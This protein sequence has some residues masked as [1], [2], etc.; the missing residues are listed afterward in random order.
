[1]EQDLKNI[2]FDFGGVLVDLDRQ[3]VFD[4][5]QKLGVRQIEQW[6]KFDLAPFVALENGT[7]TEADFYQQLRDLA[8]LRPEITDME[9]AHAWNS[10]L[11]RIPKQRLEALLR[12]RQRYRVF[13]LSN[14]NSIHWEYS[15]RHLFST[16]GLSAQDYFDRIYL[17]Y[18]LHLQ[19]PDEA[20]FRKVLE[21][22]SLEPSETIF[23]DDLEANCVAA[24]NLGL[25]TFTP[26]E[27][28]DWMPL[29]L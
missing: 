2:I 20:I 14:T 1:M 8:D 6:N 26:L 15:E 21:A 22:E 16:M 19:K 5:F 7:C 17:S 29:F 27:A 4:A 3:A 28:D 13:L 23:I 18:E 10:M 25:Q 11:V 12:L 24:R 9:L